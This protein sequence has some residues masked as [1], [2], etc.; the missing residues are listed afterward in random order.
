MTT[1]IYDEP[2]TSG[3]ASAFSNTK[4]TAQIGGRKALGDTDPVSAHAGSNHA[5]PR[6]TQAARTHDGDSIRLRVQHYLD[7]FCHAMLEGDGK[8][9]AA[10]WSRPS[11]VVDKHDTRVIRDAAEVEHFFSG[12][13]AMYHERGIVDTRAEIQ[14]LDVIDDNLVIALVRWPY[15]DESGREIGEESSTYT[16][17][18]NANGDFKMC[19]CTMRGEAGA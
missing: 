16:L 2:T 15:I 17:K 7:D 4:D 8:T 12:A 13:P 5:K 1:N 6:S 10:M 3:N 9:L 11:L 18:A 14:A 19:V